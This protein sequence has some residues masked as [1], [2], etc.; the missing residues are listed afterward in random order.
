MAI[1]PSRPGQNNG[2]GDVRA[3]FYK[4][5]AGEVLAA[6]EQKNIF[7]NLIWTRSI[8]KGKSAAFPL[9]K[10]AGDPSLF[11]PGN[12]LSGAA[13]QQTEIEIP[14]DGLVLAHTF[15]PN[16]DEW[17]NEFDV[18]SKYAAK[19]GY[20]MAK[21]VDVNVAAEL[22]KSATSG[23]NVIS[24]P[25]QAATVKDVN[26]NELVAAIW[27]AAQTLDENNV[28]DSERYLAV[29]PA[30][31]YKMFNYLSA[32]DKDYAGKG[33]IATGQILEFAGFKI[34]KSNTLK[35]VTDIAD[36]GSA[37][38]GSNYSAEGGNDHRVT[39]TETA[40]GSAGILAVA[41]A[42]EAAAMVKLRDLMVESDYDI[43]RQGEW[44]VTKMAAGFG[45]L[46]PEAAV[47]IK[48][49]AAAIA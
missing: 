29:S 31:Y 18:R 48:D 49:S 37:I 26:V 14:I 19:L 24:L 47:I 12:E 17:M 33:S 42:P 30:V 13:I 11:I 36:A 23:S 35:T 40:L 15:V 4:K 44:L 2:A 38:L 32:I 25:T 21:N 1:T 5:F 43:R 7:A 20:S 16:I 27:E 41:F 8:D 39:V 9:I 3:L 28:D 10:D 34:V 45:A 22:I 6:Y 46:R